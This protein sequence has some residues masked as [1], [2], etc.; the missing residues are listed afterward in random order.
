MCSLKAPVVKMDGIEFDYNYDTCGEEGALI[1]G[2]NF[3]LSMQSR[4]ALL[5]KNGAGKTTFMKLLIGELSPKE[6][7]GTTWVHRNLRMA[8]VAQVRSVI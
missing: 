3:K 4:C 1:K 8:Y 2:V 5:G 6:G 7:V